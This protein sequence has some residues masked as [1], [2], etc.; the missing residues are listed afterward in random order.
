MI[1]LEVSGRFSQG[2]PTRLS[3]ARNYCDTMM[4]RDL[5]AVA[6]LFIIVLTD[7]AAARRNQQITVWRFS[8]AVTCWSR[9]T[10]L[11]YIEPG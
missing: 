6:N 10:Q 5:L 1:K 4:T 3:L 2:R 9:S 11:L 7:E 8:V